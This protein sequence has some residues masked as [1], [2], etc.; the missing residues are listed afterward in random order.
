MSGE[1]IPVE[2]R[3]VAIADIFDSMITDRPYRQALPLDKAKGTINS[4]SGNLLDPECVGAFFS[5]F[6]E[7]IASKENALI[8]GRGI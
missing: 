7:I 6:D 3:I 4:Y 5:R 1:D 2:A 8:N